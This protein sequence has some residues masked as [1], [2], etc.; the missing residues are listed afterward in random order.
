MHTMPSCVTSSEATQSGTWTS[1]AAPPNPDATLSGRPIVPISTD[2]APS[3]R[4]GRR[5]VCQPTQSSR[6]PI[7]VVIAT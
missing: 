1:P 2:P 6:E 3:S 7:R 4:S 5:R